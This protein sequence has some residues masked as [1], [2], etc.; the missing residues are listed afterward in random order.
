[1][2]RPGADAGGLTI[3]Q[4]P[5]GYP[6]L[7]GLVFGGA[8]QFQNA[9]FGCGLSP[10]P[11]TRPV[12]PTG[13][14]MIGPGFFSDQWNTSFTA[15]LGAPARSGVNPQPA[16]GRLPTGQVTELGRFLRCAISSHRSSKQPARNH[17]PEGEETKSA[18]LRRC[19]P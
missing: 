14:A 3:F 16:S 5:A 17:P 4:R 6:R 11:H 13:S 10:T 8:G 2:M 18:C 15:E 1:M 9:L 19:S 7:A 12:N